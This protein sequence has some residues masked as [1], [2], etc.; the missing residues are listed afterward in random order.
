[1][2][3]GVLI[4]CSPSY[5][6]SYLLLVPDERRNLPRLSAN[7]PSSAPT[8]TCPLSSIA[9]NHQAHTES[10]GYRVDLC[11]VHLARAP[12]IATLN[13]LVGT[14]KH[15]WYIKRESVL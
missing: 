10:P 8:N 1:G 3:V 14:V 2:G 7:Q 12:N 6:K 15:A 5:R 9:R 11:R 13:H 4:C